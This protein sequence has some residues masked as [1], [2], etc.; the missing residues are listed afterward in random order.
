MEPWPSSP[1]TRAFPAKVGRATSEKPNMK[2]REAKLNYYVGLRTAM[3]QHI[4][5]T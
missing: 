4:R 3:E 1:A 5:V 2:K